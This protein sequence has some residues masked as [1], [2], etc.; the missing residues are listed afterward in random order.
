MHTSRLTVKGQITIPKELRE[1]F[2]WKPGDE[3]VL[4]R[5]ADGV[6]LVASEAA[7]KPGVALV[8]RLRGKGTRSRTTDEILSLTRGDDED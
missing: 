5:E 4:I 6:K 8:A 2:G 3:V 1:A 7:R